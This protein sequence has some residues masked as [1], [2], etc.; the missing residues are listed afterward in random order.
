MKTVQGVLNV[1]T[2]FTL[3]TQIKN[4]VHLDFTARSAHVLDKD[5]QDKEKDWLNRTDCTARHLFCEI[6][7]PVPDMTILLLTECAKYR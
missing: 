6:V 4:R 5:K 2:F 3:N 1:D 7:L